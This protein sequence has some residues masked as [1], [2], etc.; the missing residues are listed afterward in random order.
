VPEHASRFL[1]QRVA[2]DVDEAGR[3]LE[4]QPRPATA[5]RAGAV[6][7]EGDAGLASAQPI[8]TG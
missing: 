3:L 5:P 8:A 2:V 7:V 1:R 4:Q 6:A